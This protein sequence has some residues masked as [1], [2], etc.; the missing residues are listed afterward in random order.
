MHLGVAEL[1]CI[2]NLAYGAIQN[3][4]YLTSTLMIT[5]DLLTNNLPDFPQ[6]LHTNARITK[7][8]D[9]RYFLTVCNLLS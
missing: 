9:L 4:S 5:K 3:L 8:M 1:R 6:S 2:V 7:S